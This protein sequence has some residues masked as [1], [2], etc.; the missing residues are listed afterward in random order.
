M[1]LPLS[2]NPGAAF[3]IVNP[4]PRTVDAGELIAQGLRQFSAPVF[5]VLDRYQRRLYFT[6][7]S[8][9]RAAWIAALT[10]G[11]QR[12]VLRPDAGQAGNALT[13]TVEAQTDWAVPA[14]VNQVTEAQKP[15]RSPFAVLN[16]IGS[17]SYASF[18]W[19]DQSEA[20]VGFA[21]Y[22]DPDSVRAAVTAETPDAAIEIQPYQT[23]NFT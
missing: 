11:T 13:W 14:L 17:Q 15:K 7:D 10:G 20:R 8:A 23:G 22:L 4:T 5:V 18:A 19:L 16:L 21:D 6:T 3:A 1:A 2:G 12:L 9:V